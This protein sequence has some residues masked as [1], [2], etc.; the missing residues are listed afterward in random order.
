MR[1]NRKSSYRQ[2]QD[3]NH[4]V[5]MVDKPQLLIRLQTLKLLPLMLFSW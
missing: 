5:R 2:A 1:R 3:G 4:M